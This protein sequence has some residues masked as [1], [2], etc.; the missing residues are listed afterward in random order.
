MLDVTGYYIENEES[1]IETDYEI[2]E[3]LICVN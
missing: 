1:E 2:W 3:E